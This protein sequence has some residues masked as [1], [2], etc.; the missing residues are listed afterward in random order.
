VKKRQRSDVPLE[1]SHGGPARK[2]VLIQPG[3]ADSDLIYLNEAE[4]PP[5]TS[6]PVHAH[7]DMEEVFLIL[8]GRGTI[9]VVNETAPLRPGDRVIVPAQVPHALTNTGRLPL[10]LITFGVRVRGAGSGGPAGR[11]RAG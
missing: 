5:G 4:V 1:V 3:D 8:A 10:R 6:V 9:Q 11:T 2:R 7:P